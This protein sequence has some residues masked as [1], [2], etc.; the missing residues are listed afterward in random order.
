MPAEHDNTDNTG[1]AGNVAGTGNVG[2]AENVGNVAGI[3]N[4]GSAENTGN[5]GN[6]RDTG[7]SDGTVGAAPRAGGP[8]VPDALLAALVDA[9]LPPEARTDPVFLAEYEA[10]AADLALLRDQ[11]RRIG[12]TLADLPAPA[13]AVAP[14]HDSAAP[15]SDGSAPA[16]GPARASGRSPA[17]G[18]LLRPQPRRT[19]FPRVVGGIVAVLVVSVIA[20]TGWLVV[21]GSGG[22]QRADSSS[23][24]QSAGR[25]DRGCAR[26][27]VEGDVVRVEAGPGDGRER[28]TVRVTRYYRPDRGA[29]QVTVVTDRSLAPRPHEGD[30]VLLA[31]PSR[32]STPDLWVTGEA[33]IA[34]R[35]AAV[36]K[37]TA[38]SCPQG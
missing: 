21:R 10:A 24:A 38:E 30:H 5:A 1:N 36:R 11:V 13:P 7:S 37:E 16:P 14:E 32:G 4:T 15:A 29:E 35:R 33:D 12:D 6:V 3:G 22:G 34:A 25:A 28:V 26:L 9:P 31:L 20:G 17:T 19:W 23:A 27:V 8:A 2:S 18:S